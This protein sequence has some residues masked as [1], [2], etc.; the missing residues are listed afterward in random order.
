[1]SFTAR[2]FALIAVPAF[3]LLAAEKED[4]P[5]YG[6]DPGGQRFSLLTAINKSNLQ[7]LKIAWTYRTGDAYAPKSG[8][9]PT[10][11]EATPLYVDGTLYIGTPLGRIIALD[12]VTGNERWT[13]DPHINKDKGYGDNATRGVSTWKS[14]SGERRIY[15]ATID[16]RLISVDA[17]TGKPCR[18]FG[19]NGSVDLRHGLRIA[20]R[21]FADYEETSPPAVIG[22][23]LIVGSGIQD[24]GWTDEPSGEVRAFDTTTGKLKW[25]WDPIPQDPHAVGAETWK[26]G[27]AAHT[28]A[29]NAWSVI[30]VDPAR[31]L[32]FVPTGSASPDYYGGLRPGNNLFADSIVA[33]R[34]DTGERVWHFQTVHHD[35]WDYDVAT[36]PLL[37][38]IH[39]N[40]QTIPAIAVGS[41]TANL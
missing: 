19:D 7:S 30:A 28:G 9:K 38:D 31:N 16:A 40:G 14:P 33:L 15:I 2:S 18:D 34:A 17:L 35:L 21:G 24:N 39:R 11:F 20:P 29:A 26:D 6:H 12:P 3:L 22:N 4:W 1:M 13:Y 5:T 36:P 25:S 41:K 37:F 32:V 10:Q 8:S 23:L 27:S